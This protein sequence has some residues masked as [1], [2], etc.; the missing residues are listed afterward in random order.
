MY[1][2][3]QEV[4]AKSKCHC[5]VLPESAHFAA[6]TSH[7]VL[8]LKL[9]ACTGDCASVAPCLIMGFNDILAA[10]EWTSAWRAP[11]R[12]ARARCART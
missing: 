6:G 1:S 10:G 8:R 12:T 4:V 7:L 2:G 3:I 9:L 11:M 5:L